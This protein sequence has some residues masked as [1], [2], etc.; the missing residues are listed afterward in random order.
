MQFYCNGLWNKRADN[1]NFMYNNIKIAA[2]QETKQSRES[3]NGGGLAFNL[4]RSVKYKILSS[5]R[6]IFCK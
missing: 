2:I 3:D 1:T 5:I 4:E 6:T